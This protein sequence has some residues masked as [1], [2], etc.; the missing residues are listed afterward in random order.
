MASSDRRALARRF[1]IDL[2]LGRLVPE[3]RRLLSRQD[4]GADVLAGITV[5]FVAI[6]LSLA[7]AVASDV[8]PGRGLVSAI[9]AGIACGLFGGTPLAISGPAAAMA[10]L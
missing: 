9:V 2:G 4:L 7:I 3:W 10:V 5:G 6:P 1:R 8:P